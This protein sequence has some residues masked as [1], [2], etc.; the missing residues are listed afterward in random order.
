MHIFMQLFVHF[1][2]NIR[3]ERDKN[4]NIANFF[5]VLFL[6]LFSNLINL[7]LSNVSIHEKLGLETRD[8]VF[9][10]PSVRLR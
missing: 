1:M 2:S 4:V 5:S 3:A 6:E 8:C 7:C 9:F 10:K